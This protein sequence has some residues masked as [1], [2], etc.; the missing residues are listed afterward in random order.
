MTGTPLAVRRDALGNALGGLRLPQIDVPTAR[1]DGIGTPLACRLQGAAVPFARDTLRSLYRD[2][3]TYVS[4]FAQATNRAVAAGVLLGED[5][6]AAKQQAAHA[7]V[8]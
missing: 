6:A 1:Y 2:H 4:R 3:E 5:A 8:P 7:P